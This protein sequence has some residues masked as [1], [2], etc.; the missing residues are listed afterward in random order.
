M[1]TL[2]T[3]THAERAGYA[4]LMVVFLAALAV[5]A[6]GGALTWTSSSR[7]ATVRNNLYYSSVAAAEAA[8]EKA[9][10]LMAYD[11]RQGDQS[12]IWSSLTTYRAAVPTT[13][14]DASWSGYTFQDLA[15]N[16]GVLTVTNTTLFA[17]TNLVGQYKNLRGV[18]GTFQVAA[19]AVNSS[20]TE[21]VP[22]A[23]QQEVQ[24]ATIPVFQF[25][26]YYNILMEISCG[27]TF[28]IWGPV[29]ANQDMYVE[30][31]S[32]MVFWDDVGA[33]G[34]INFSRAPGDGRTPPSGTV[35]Y[36]GS[37]TAGMG[38]L[39]LPIGTNNSA[40]AIAALLDP[41]P[42]NEVATSAMGKQRF[43]NKADMIITVSNSTITASSGIANSLTVITNA[44]PFITTNSSFTDARESKTVKAINIDIGKFTTWNSTNTS[45]RTLEGKPV[46]TLYVVDKRTGL[47]STQLGAVRLTNG[48]VIPSTGLTV[49]TPQPLYI[50]G[51]YNCFN[52]NGLGSTNTTYSYPAAVMAD[53][54]TILSGNW[55]DGNSTAAVGSRNATPTTVNAAFLTGEV[56]TSVHGSYSGGAENFPRFLETWGSAN[57]FTYN[58]SMV[59]MFG[60]RYATNAWG[61]SNVYGPP[62]RNWTYDRNFNDPAKL[63]PST[64][65]VSTLIRSHWA[66]LSTH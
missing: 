7:R 44:L 52:T 43:Y 39:S 3:K 51:N 28:N 15:G 32:T 38:S 64:P 24:L 31:D 25:A 56:E 66:R 35:T 59:A 48:V 18:A 17:F 50:D 8:T 46:G 13:A 63:P 2:L 22:A 11:F 10:G 23:V 61:Q 58:G 42:T 62:A 9:V 53:A 55:T 29:H 60:S 47:T 5:M 41:P 26:I 19:K 12:K 36:K 37:H 54:I 14:E 20:G 33:V 45:L 27:Q 49:V 21:I 6:V 30:P 1:R 65:S 4:L 16:S 34:S 40:A 57:T